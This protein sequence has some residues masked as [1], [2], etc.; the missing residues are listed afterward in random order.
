MIAPCENGYT[1]YLDESLDEQGR[2][3]AY[4]HAIGHIAN[5]DYE[6][7]DVQELESRAHGIVA[8]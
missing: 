5:S 7:S 1:I 3:S 8:P 4:T 6:K 2:L